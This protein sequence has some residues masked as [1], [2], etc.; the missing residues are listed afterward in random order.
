MV[1]DER[2]YV[3]RNGYAISVT[4]SSKQ[5]AKTIRRRLFWQKV[6]LRLKF[7]VFLFLV[8]LCEG[9]D[10]CFNAQ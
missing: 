1:T 5:K 8:L 4:L 2:N 7:T 3:R 6:M 10:A 9:G